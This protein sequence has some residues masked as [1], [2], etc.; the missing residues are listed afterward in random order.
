MRFEPFV[1]DNTR[2]ERLYRAYTA[3]RCE[4][5]DLV[6]DDANT[7]I[8]DSFLWAFIQQSNWCDYWRAEYGSMENKRHIASAFSF[9]TEQYVKYMNGVAPSMLK[10][11]VES[12]LYRCFSPALAPTA[13]SFLTGT[14]KRSYYS[15]EEPKLNKR[16]RK[17][18]AVK[19]LASL[20]V[21]EV[22]E[23]FAT[24]VVTRIMNGE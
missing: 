12:M 7:R 16:V 9:A 15:E 8:P 14:K 11:S 10:P 5:K 17:Q 23:I 4:A 20:P 24:E 1:R 6:L 21:E 2:A 22:K 18:L 19:L 13:I 3:L